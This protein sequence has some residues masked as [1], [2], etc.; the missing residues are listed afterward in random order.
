MPTPAFGSD[1]F[2][3]ARN[4]AGKGVFRRRS[5]PHRLP[6]ARLRPACGLKRAKPG[7]RR[8][9]SPAAAIVRLDLSARFLLHTHTHTHTHTHNS[10]RLP[11]RQAGRSGR[12]PER[13]GIYSRRSDTLSGSAL[14]A[15]G[16]APFA[17]PISIFLQ[18]TYR[19]ARFGASR[20]EMAP[21]SVR[22]IAPSNH[23]S[24]R[25]L[26][27]HFPRI[28]FGIIFSNIM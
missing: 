27:L 28:L 21:R 23:I 15:R 26:R 12:R 2:G 11:G 10:P 16:G 9:R 13:G 25:P 24:L 7:A 1:R 14:S 8:D 17:F 22:H 6:A 20:A 3:I 5:G 18:T 19:F 4:D